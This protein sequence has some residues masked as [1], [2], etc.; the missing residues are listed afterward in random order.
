MGGDCGTWDW[1]AARDAR[2]T[3]LLSVGKQCHVRVRD[4]PWSQEKTP[5]QRS[6]RT[7]PDQITSPVRQTRDYNRYTGLTTVDAHP[8]RPLSQACHSLDQP[9]ITTTMTVQNIRDIS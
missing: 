7:S 3:T 8:A 6:E 2:G 9:H 5:R 4:G 1:S